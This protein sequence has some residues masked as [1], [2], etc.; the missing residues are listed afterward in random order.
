LRGHPPRPS[1][2]VPN[3]EKEKEHTDDAES[4]EDGIGDTDADRSNEGKDAGGLNARRGRKSS[5]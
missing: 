3:H 2:S 1:F 4:G 5:A